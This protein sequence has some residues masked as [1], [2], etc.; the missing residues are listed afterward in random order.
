MKRLGCRSRDERSHL[1]GD[2][3]SFDRPSY[4]SVSIRIRGSTSSF[5]GHEIQGTSALRT[6]AGELHL[7]RDDERGRYA[8][9]RSAL[10]QYPASY[11]P[12]L[13]NNCSAPVSFRAG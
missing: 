11:F 9:R 6:R 5:F 8:R 4:L 2:L 7:V 3:P 10:A 1:G 13:A 12:V